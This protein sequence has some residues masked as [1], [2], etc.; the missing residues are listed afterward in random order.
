MPNEIFNI[1][2]NSDLATG[3]STVAENF[4][5]DWSRLPDV[6]YH[7]S[8]T[9]KSAYVA[10]TNAATIVNIFVDLGCSHTYFAGPPSGGSSSSSMFLGSLN[11]TPSAN[12]YLQCS[13][14]DNT[15]IYLRGRP[16]NNNV[17]VQLNRNINN[18]TTEYTPVSGRY[19]LCLCL[20]ALE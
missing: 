2:F 9:F 19:T 5:F 17:F 18:Q 1:V 12:T 16:R 4:F 20:R 3:T 13:E 8:F 14:T 6:P 10:A 15:P 7:V 11:V